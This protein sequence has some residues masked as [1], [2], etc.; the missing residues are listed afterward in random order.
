[1]KQIFDT[2]RM[3]GTSFHDNV[4]VATVRELTELIGEPNFSN[5]TGEDKTNFE[6]ILENS[7][8]DAFTLYDWKNYRPL[9]M[10][11][12]V[13]WH[14]GARSAAIS[15]TSKLELKQLIFAVSE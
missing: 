11:E 4:I 5:N 8:G 3:N 13:E 12:E 15:L 14:I 1:M 9:G 10:D 6:W 2:D 7:E